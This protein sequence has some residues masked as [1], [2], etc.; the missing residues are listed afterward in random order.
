MPN[1]VNHHK[2][3]PHIGEKTVSSSN[4]VGESDYPYVEER[5]WNH[6]TN[7]DKGQLKDPHGTLKLTEK[8]TGKIF[9]DTG[10]IKNFQKCLR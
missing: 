6:T 5:N 7:L 1:Q 9:Q 10:T 2:S 4:D 8:N 3:K